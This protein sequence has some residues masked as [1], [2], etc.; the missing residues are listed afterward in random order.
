MT[1]SS[2]QIVFRAMH[3]IPMKTIQTGSEDKERTHCLHY[4]PSSQL[5]TL[6]TGTGVHLNSSG[7]N[8]YPFSFSME[9]FFWG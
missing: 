1:S 9:G 3:E 4:S 5:T 6:K 2:L 7:F 8:L